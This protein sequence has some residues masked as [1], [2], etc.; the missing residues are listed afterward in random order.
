[1][2]DD[3]FERISK[4]ATISRYDRAFAIDE[5][6]IQR[7]SRDAQTNER[8]RE[9]HILHRGDSDALQRMVNALQP[10]SYIR[11]HRHV[12]PPKSETIVLLRGSLGFMT[13]H[14]DGTPDERDFIHLHPAKAVGV[15]CRE[16]IWHTF[17]ALEPDT[18]VF[19]V[20]AGPHDAAT[21]KEFAVWAPD[22]TSPDAQRYL[23]RLKEIF[24]QG[25]T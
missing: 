14:D 23:A 9:I 2:H 22:E 12:R 24:R 10:S 11:P 21:D 7:K 15:D 3:H 5:E 16:G 17:F 6:L 18:V 25:L 8:Q 20:K 19:E 1:V 4:A 13:F